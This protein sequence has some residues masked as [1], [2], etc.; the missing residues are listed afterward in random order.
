M[1]QTVHLRA[2]LVEVIMIEL[3][4]EKALL[5]RALPDNIAPRVDHHRVAEAKSVL[6]IC[7]SILGRRNNIGLVL[8]RPCS[9]E[10]FPVSSACLG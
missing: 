3:A 9:E 6:V 7:P 10:S 1:S 5:V 8:N 4:H 2:D